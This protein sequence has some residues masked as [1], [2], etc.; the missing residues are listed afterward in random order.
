MSTGHLSSDASQAA[1]K[2]FFGV[3]KDFLDPSDR[4]WEAIDL[5]ERN[6]I[7]QFEKDPTG[8]WRW[9]RDALIADTTESEV[10]QLLVLRDIA[11]E[12]WPI[13][14]ENKEDDFRNNTEHCFFDKHGVEKAS[15]K[16]FARSIV[17]H[18]DR[19]ISLYQSACE[20]INVSTSFEINAQVGQTYFRMIKTFVRLME[21]SKDGEAGHYYPNDPYN[22]CCLFLIKKLT[23][24]ANDTKTTSGTTE[25]ETLR[26]GI[27][28]I[29]TFVEK[30]S[31]K[32]IFWIGAPTVQISPMP[33]SE[34]G[35]PMTTCHFNKIEIND[36]GKGIFKLGDYLNILPEEL[37]FLDELLLWSKQHVSLMDELRGLQNAYQS[38]SIGSFDIY[39]DK[40]Y[41]GSG[42]KS[43]GPFALTVP[44]LD[45]EAFFRYFEAPFL[46]QKRGVAVSSSAI[47]MMAGNTLPSSIET[48]AEYCEILNTIAP[49]Q[50]MIL[51]KTS[52]FVSSGFARFLQPFYLERGNTKINLQNVYYRDSQ[53]RFLIDFFCTT[54]PKELLDILRNPSADSSQKISEEAVEKA[55]K[56]AVQKIAEF[57][58]QI[59]A[60]QHNLVVL[61]NIWGKIFELLNHVGEIGVFKVLPETLEFSRSYMELIKNYKNKVTELQK[62][63]R[64][65]KG[66]ISSEHLGATTLLAYQ[67]LAL[68][69]LNEKLTDLQQRAQNVF[70]TSSFKLSEL[71]KRIVNTVQMIQQLKM[72]IPAAIEAMN[73][74]CGSTKTNTASL[75]LAPISAETGLEELGGEGISRTPVSLTSSIVANRNRFFEPIRLDKDMDNSFAKLNERI[76]E[77]D[78]E[79]EMICKE[80]IMD[81]MDLKNISKEDKIK[82]LNKFQK[83]CIEFSKDFSW[84]DEVRMEACEKIKISPEKLEFLGS[85]PP[86][87][88]PE[89]S[90][91]TSRCLPQ[92]LLL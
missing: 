16:R 87:L 35:L 60:H 50:T 89:S 26:N 57:H 81:M 32:N 8:Q 27:K 53:V 64:N 13:S 49:S 48:Q 39:L 42:E 82:L 45:K 65:T 68:N 40:L 71:E 78:E 46:P 74:I 84:I 47:I 88:D 73:N 90:T 5:P 20:K 2:S 86:P 24:L 67:E 43:Q 9:G 23:K 83:M 25:I 72:E 75:F 31:R 30:V 14:P 80:F 33:S 22:L 85:L 34:P 77:M 6:G 36:I 15:K 70:E 91:A 19:D 44:P 52:Y 92:C 28:K 21:Q 56:K 63:Y 4:Y 51:N 3:M 10:F 1:A 29:S 12:V 38:L 69:N 76:E 41:I 11:E 59:I 7:V 37:Q 58:C 18:K 66:A 17:T 61:N 79:K 54:W 55:R 62:L